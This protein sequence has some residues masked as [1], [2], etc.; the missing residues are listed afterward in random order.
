MSLEDI[1]Q[2]VLAD[3][4]IN[5]RK[6]LRRA[7]IAFKHILAYFGKDSPASA[8]SHDTLSLYASARLEKVVAGT[9]KIELAIFRKGFSLLERAGKLVSPLFPR[10]SLDNVRQGFFEDHELEAVLRHLPED[11]R[12]MLRFLNLTGWRVSEASGLGWRNIDF[13]GGAVRLEPGTTKNRDGRTFPFD[14]LP[15]LVDIIRN[16]RAATDALERKY[17]RIIPTVFWREHGKTP[18]TLG[19]RPVRDFKRAWKTAC[20]RSG[21]PGRRVHDLRRT[22]VRRLERAGVPRSVA[23]RLTGHR[24]E[25]VYQ[26]YAISNERDL[27]EGLTKL[28]DFIRRTKKDS[29]CDE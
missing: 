8:I 17:G 29:S 23:M 12:P 24:S 21:Y 11:L 5:G 4:R 2:A 6:S 18:S 16:Q 13:K 28:A 26:R 3:Y 1:H 9:V 14:V 20:L 27:R 25:S 10:I 22:A 15:D 19:A 7:E